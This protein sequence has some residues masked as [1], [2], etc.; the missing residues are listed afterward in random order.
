MVGYLGRILSR[1]IGLL[2]VGLGI[3]TLSGR[4][5]PANAMDPGAP[6]I[7]PVAPGADP[8]TVIMSYLVSE[9]S[10]EH[11]VPVKSQVWA[12]ASNFNGVMIG[13]RI[14]YYC[15]LSDVSFDPLCRGVVGEDDIS[16]WRVI[17]DGDFAVVVYTLNPATQQLIRRH[18][19]I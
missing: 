17:E 15:L 16:I 19:P 14:F 9:R 13:N 12:K 8:S 4:I 5:A 6:V 11:L 1:W 18:T 3:L 10:D 7:A 2:V